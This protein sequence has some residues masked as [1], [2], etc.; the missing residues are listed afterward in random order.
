MRRRLREPTPT[1]LSCLKTPVVAVFYITLSY[2]Y[3]KL[4]YCINI[5]VIEMHASYGAQTPKSPSSSS[6]TGS[7]VGEDVTQVQ[8]S[9]ILKRKR[10][11][12]GRFVSGGTNSSIY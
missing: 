1:N 8:K 11:N 10:K 5:I 2:C 9:G 12:F 6:D 3:K 7:S 4:K